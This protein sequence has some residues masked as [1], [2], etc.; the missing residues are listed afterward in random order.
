MAPPRKMPLKDLVAAANQYADT[1]P[2]PIIKEFA[3]IVGYT[4]EYLYELAATHPKSGLRA[5]LQRII[6]RKE[7]AL[8]RGALSGELDRSMAIFSLKQLGWRDQPPEQKNDD[9]LDEIL[10]SIKDAADKC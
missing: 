8:E 4:R 2:I 6:D 5:A 9:K 10:R 3:M 1:T 7:I